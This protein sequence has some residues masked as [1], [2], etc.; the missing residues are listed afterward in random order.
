MTGSR[1]ATLGPDF[2]NRP[3]ARFSPNGGLI[4]TPHKDEVIRLWRA[5][6]GSPIAALGGHQHSLT[7]LEFSS[8]GASLLTA[9]D[10]GTARLWS[11]EPALAGRLLP[12]PTSKPDPGELVVP[13][14]HLRDQIKG[15]VFSTEGSRLLV[16]QSHRAILYDVQSGRQIRI[17][18]TPFRGDLSSFL[19][20]S[21][22]FMLIERQSSFAS[23]WV[24]SIYSGDNGHLIRTFVHP[25]NEDIRWSLA[26]RGKYVVGT[27]E[28]GTLLA[29]DAT[30]GQVVLK[31]DGLGIRGFEEIVIDRDEQRALVRTKAG[32]A[33]I[34]EIKS[35]AVS[36]KLPTKGGLSFWNRDGTRV[37]NYEGIWDIQAA[38]LTVAFNRADCGAP[39]DWSEASHR[40]AFIHGI[41]SVVFCLMDAQTGKFV[42]TV[43]YLAAE[44]HTRE[45][46]AVRF[47]ADGRR[48]VTV[49]DD[50][51]AR[52]WDSATGKH[53]ALL[54]RARRDM[55]VDRETGGRGFIP[56]AISADGQSIVTGHADGVV[57]VWEAMG[58]GL[59]AELK[60]LRG[61]VSEVA[62]DSSGRYVAAGSWENML[63]IWPLDTDLAKTAAIAVEKTV[64]CLGSEERVDVGL[65]SSLPDWCFEFRKWPAPPLRVGFEME[66]TLGSMDV[67]LGKSPVGAGVRVVRVYRNL[68][69]DKAGIRVGDAIIE[70]NG[71][72]MTEAQL[73]QARIAELP[74]G[75]VAKFKVDRNGAAIELDLI[76]RQ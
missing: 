25:V 55:A 11:I 2:S 34:V 19:A 28:G 69:A 65:E 32:E 8:D 29:W 40:L 7:A 64:R 52:L 35:G 6:D 57:R 30:N 66:S 47:V 26:G 13:G 44:R 54:G 22:N 73:V 1:L 15:V 20:D 75:M 36:A 33:L 14:L 31:L 74:I 51:S 76:P 71:H 5:S 37:A 59:V 63:F 61:G 23:P 45:I 49:A 42:R 56:Y 58:G 12:T 27:S 21:R 70:I 10:D 43:D 4:A 3:S 17:I 38:K 53:I 68:P 62:I 18:E 50:D 39:R 60:G 41:N 16:A 9:A 72:P 24:A 67:V 46:G 48:V